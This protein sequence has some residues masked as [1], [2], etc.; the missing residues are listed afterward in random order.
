MAKEEKRCKEC[1]GM[2]KECKCPPKKYKKAKY[3]WY[4]LDRD[5]DGDDDMS[6][7]H[8]GANGEGGL[9]EAA[10]SKIKPPTEQELS[11]LSPD[12][13]QKRLDDF[14]AHVADAKKRQEYKSAHDKLYSERIRKGIRFYDAKGS[15]YIRDGKKQYD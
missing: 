5:H 1:E 3:G 14:K 6:V 13:R 7:D 15:G 2:G 4:G 12:N 8:V 10:G 11:G 9:G